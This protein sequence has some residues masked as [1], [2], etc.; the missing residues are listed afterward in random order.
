MF[1]IL[2]T[3]CMKSSHL[4]IPYSTMFD[5]KGEEKQQRSQEKQQMR[6]EM[7]KYKENQKRNKKGKTIWS[8][9]HSRQASHSSIC[10]Q[11]QPWFEIARVRKQ[12]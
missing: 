7:K 1:R 2:A 12:Q 3:V 11:K 4:Y 9:N 6:K 10:I 8:K 5:S